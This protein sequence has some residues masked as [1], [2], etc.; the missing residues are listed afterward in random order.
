MLAFIIL[1]RFGGR[2]RDGGKTILLLVL[3][4]NDIINN[5]FLFLI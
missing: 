2:K 5:V 1:C 3:T 4:N